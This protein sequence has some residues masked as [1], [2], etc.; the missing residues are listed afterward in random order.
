MSR[1]DQ[2]VD[3]RRFLRLAGATTAGVGAWSVSEP[4]RTRAFASRSRGQGETAAD[5]GRLPARPDQ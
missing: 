2:A 5:E 3:R 4:T 1:R